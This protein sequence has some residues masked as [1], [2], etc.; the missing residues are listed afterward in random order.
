MPNEPIN[1]RKWLPQ[2]ST[3]RTGRLFTCGRPGR[4]TPAYGTNRIPVDDAVI[5]EWVGGLPLTGP[6]HI[7]SLLGRKRDSYSEFGYYPFRSCFGDEESRPSFQKWLNRQYARRFLVHEFPTID[8]QGIE[9]GTM[10]RI[11]FC[12]RNLLFKERTVLIVDSAGAERTARVCEQMPS[13]LA[14]VEKALI[15]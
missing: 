1:L 14:H 10:Q 3:Q 15:S 13:K 4:G 11:L 7:V 5:D 8:S 6:L 12:V 2:S 9:F